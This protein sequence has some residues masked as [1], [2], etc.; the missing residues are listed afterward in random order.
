ME[1]NMMKKHLQ[2]DNEDEFTLPPL[3]VGVAGGSA[4]GKSS[5]CENIIKELKNEHNSSFTVISL[6]SYYKSLANIE[7]AK[8]YNFDHPDALDWD[9]AYD[10][11]QT[12]L[13][14]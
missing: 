1:D 9:M 2:G 8:D 4:S 5:L 6:D 13:S 3:L 14:R 12:L 11:I 10:N 7:M